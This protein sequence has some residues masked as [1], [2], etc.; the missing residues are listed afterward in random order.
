VQLL[1]RSANELALELRKSFPVSSGNQRRRKEL[2]WKEVQ[3]VPPPPPSLL[4]VV[5]ELKQN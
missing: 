1:N 4:K 5:K 3:Q 2:E